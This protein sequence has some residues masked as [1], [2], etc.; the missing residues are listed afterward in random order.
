MR[1]SRMIILKLM[2]NYLKPRVSIKIKFLP[3][4]M[5]KSSFRQ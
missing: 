5:Q 1:M 3:P 4:K 2:L